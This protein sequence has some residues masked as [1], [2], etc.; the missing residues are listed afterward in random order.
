MTVREDH[1]NLR[2]WGGRT[3]RWQSVSG[4]KGA[5][6]GCWRKGEAARESGGN[7]SEIGTNTALY[8]TV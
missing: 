8:M 3:E 1:E 5:A 4:Q 6:R 2:E 7:I